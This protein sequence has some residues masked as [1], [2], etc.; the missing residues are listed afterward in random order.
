MSDTWQQTTGPLPT[1]LTEQQ[2]PG[3]PLPDMT[4]AVV[5]LCDKAA[6][7]IAQL[8]SG[9]SIGVKPLP[10]IFPAYEIQIRLIPTPARP[11]ES[12]E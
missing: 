5:E 3:R 7:F 10:S 8:Q 2:R 4:A 6:Q 1:V 9:Q 11:A 12:E